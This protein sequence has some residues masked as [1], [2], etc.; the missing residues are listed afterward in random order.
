MGKRNMAMFEDAMRV[1]APFPQPSRDGEATPE[2]DQTARRGAE[3]A[4]MRELRA[5]LDMLQ[6]Q[7]DRLLK[8]SKPDQT[9]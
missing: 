3:S 8:S 9:K 5:K 4:E 6:E 1:F 7:L 2:T